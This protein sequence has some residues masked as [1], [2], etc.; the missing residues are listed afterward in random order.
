MSFLDDDKYKIIR[1]GI[2][3]LLL[4]FLVVLNIFSFF[5]KKKSVVVNPDKNIALVSKEEVKE[6]EKCIKESN[7]IRIDVKGAVVNQGVY[8]LKEGDIVDDALKAAG[9]VTSKGITK[10]I[11]LSKK[12]EDQMVIYVY[13]NA[14]L[15]NYRKE[16][17]IDIKD[18]E[19]KEVCNCP[20]Y[21]IS[22]CEGASIISGSNNDNYSYDNSGD[23]SINKK[24][25]LNTASKEELLTLSGIGESKAIAIIEYRDK[26]GRFNNI[27]DIKNVTGIGE[28]LFAKI[29]ENITI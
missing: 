29:K 22:S 20:K 15:N 19:E 23:V 7:D 2:I 13:T 8:V 6:E 5:N 21:E 27:E 12:L 28:A 25:N 18:N 14:E 4:S 3:V 11:N 26:N 10:N 24:V 9:G 17:N 16:N 1:D